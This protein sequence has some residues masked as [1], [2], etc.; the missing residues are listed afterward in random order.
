MIIEINT[1]RLLNDK[2]LDEQST[3][4]GPDMRQNFQENIPWCLDVIAGSQDYVLKQL[5][6]RWV[7]ELGH[8]PEVRN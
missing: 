6:Q 5:A 8:C 1:N 7:V 3:R 4:I 2:I